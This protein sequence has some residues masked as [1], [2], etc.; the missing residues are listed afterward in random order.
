MPLTLPPATQ[1]ILEE[2][3]SSTEPTVDYEI[4]GK[5]SGIHQ[6]EGLTTDERKGALA[7]ATAF[8]LRLMDESPWHTRYGPMFTVAKQDGTPHYA[9]DIAEID[10]EMI[11]HWEQRSSAIQHPLLRARY[12]DVTWDL[13]KAVTGNPAT[14]QL[15]HRA[16]DAYLDGVVTK[17]C[18][19]PSVIAVQ[20]CQ[21][22]LDIAL[23]INDKNR[24]AH[25]KTVM[26]D[27]FL[28][29]AQ[30][31]HIGVWATLYD[32]L[33]DNKKVGLTAAQ[34]DQLVNG[35]QHILDTASTHGGATFD[36]WSA[37]AAA[38]RLAAHYERQGKKENAQIAIRAYGTAFE[39]LAAQASPLLAMSWLQGVHQEY[40]NRGM[41][42]DATRVQAASTEKGKHVASEMKEVRASV[43]ITD[44]QMRKF[45]EAMTSGTPRDA[46]LR[47]A[48]H[49]VP[50]TEDVKEFLKRL[51]Q[52]AP[53]TSM[54]G[55]TKV[56]GDHFAAQ[57]GSTENDPE[58][59][60]IMQLAQNIQIQNVFLYRG[61]ERLRATNIITA[62]TILSVIAE[63][64]I[65]PPERHALLREGIQA[66][67]SRATTPKQST[68]SSR[69]SSKH[70]A[71]S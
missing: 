40:K 30:P 8:N 32:A 71:N 45:V 20:A 59:R 58:G 43:E 23:T 42:A 14:V 18:K 7:E 39:Q 26:L 35:L 57:A 70:F 53:F 10:E 15:A 37:E 49:F 31:G 21:R 19:E 22:A 56:V 61:I 66:H 11:N 13:K 25:C 6:A 44:E 38:R 1:K 27:L 16:I 17:R 4:A 47:M 24:I 50:K 34:V 65:F 64:P 29:N 54:I 51:Q 3:E 2:Y 28:A 36:P 5:L 69:K 68:S 48:A 9:P 12:A 60:L 67:P 41:N 55:V 33:T 52:D 62:D 63:S 46:L